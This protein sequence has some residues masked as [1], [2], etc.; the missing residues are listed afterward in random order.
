MTTT[1]DFPGYTAPVWLKTVHCAIL[2]TGLFQ[3][4]YLLACFAIMAGA[5]GQ[6]FVEKTSELLNEA[7]AKVDELHSLEAKVITV[8]QA[9]IEVKPEKEVPPDSPTDSTTQ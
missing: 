3:I 5:A 8:P 7:R 4:T 9:T 1:I 2:L 6:R